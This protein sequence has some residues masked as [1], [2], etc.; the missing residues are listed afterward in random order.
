M[1][2][3]GTEIG[4]MLGESNADAGLNHRATA[5]PEDGL[6]VVFDEFFVLGP[7]GEEAEDRVVPGRGGED[8]AEALGDAGL[9]FCSAWVWVMM[10]GKRDSMGVLR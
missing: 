1:S 7:F 9:V 4:R 6:E 3:I 8:G 10:T 5:I 2:A